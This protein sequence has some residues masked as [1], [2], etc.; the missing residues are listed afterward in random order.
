MHRGKRATPYEQLNQHGRKI[1]AEVERLQRNRDEL[2]MQRQESGFGSTGSKET[3]HFPNSRESSS[4]ANDG[5]KRQGDGRR[6]HP[7]TIVEESSRDQEAVT[8]DRIS[9]IKQMIGEL[10]EDSRL[11]NET[12]R[13]RLKN[14]QQK[15]QEIFDELIARP[16]KQQTNRPTAAH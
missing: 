1:E 15:Q 10:I 7:S 11:S 13:D 2:M 16:S 3:G 12:V 4:H 9:S 14:I 5:R 8:S 6:T